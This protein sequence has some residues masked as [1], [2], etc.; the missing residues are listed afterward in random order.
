MNA[1][2]LNPPAA[3]AALAWSDAL[4]LGFPEMDTEHRDFVDRV[5]A[6]QAAG[7][8]TVAQRLAEFAEHARRHFGA[9]DQWM[10]S[11]DFPPRQCH[12]DEHAAVL[13]SVQEVQALVA[14]G[15]T[16]IV[17]SL[18]DELVRWFPGHAHHLDSALAA[19]M[20]KRKWDAKPVV[21]RRHVTGDSAQG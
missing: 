11:T 4:L 19:W 1:A 21:I 14:A 12:I 9:E 5:L 20:C 17:R 6:L 13:K 7:P 18:A 2:A 10:A 8:D 3:E 16:A 15:N